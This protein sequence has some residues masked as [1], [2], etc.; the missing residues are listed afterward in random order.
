MQDESSE[1]PP[2]FERGYAAEQSP[3]GSMA[4]VVIGA[5]VVAGL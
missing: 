2:R 3:V 5:I 1:A 4:R